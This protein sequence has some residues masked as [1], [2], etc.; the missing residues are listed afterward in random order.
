MKCIHIHIEG[1]VQGVGF[2]PFVYRLA[3]ELG[4]SGWVCNGV[5]GVHVE[6]EGETEQLQKFIQQLKVNHPPIARITQCRIEECSC[7]NFSE[8][9]IAESEFSGKPNLLITPD[10]GLCDDCR[11]EVHN[12]ANHRYQYPFT[13]CTQCGPR[14]SIMRS[15]P[16]DRPATSMDEFAMCPTCLQEYYNP[17]DKRYYSQTNS[18]PDCAIK[19]RL[20]AASGETIASDW[21]S[22]FPIVIQKLHEGSIIAIKGIGGYLLVCDATKPKAIKTLRKRKH[23]PT[24]PFALMY[25][26]IETLQQDACVSDSEAL[27]FLSIQS[28][29]VLVKVKAHPASGICKELIA[30]GLMRM[31]AMQP[32]TAMFDL[33]MAAFGKPLIATSAN[34]S[35]SPII[36][37]DDDALQLL[38][39]I[40]DYFVVHNRD[41]EIAQ[42]D[43]VVQFSSSYNQRIVLRRSRGFAPTVS[44]D[45]FSKETMLAMGAD[46]KSA[47]CLQ[48]NGRI[49][50][51]QYLGDLESYESQESFRKALF[52]LMDLVKAKPKRI[53]IDAHPNY[54]SSQ[55]G[56][57][58]AENWNIP[59]TQVQ[60]HAAHAYAVMA[61]NSLLDTDE[62]IL[63]VIWDGTGYG[64]DGNSWGGE[65]FEYNG[66]SLKRIAQLHYAPV[67][68]GDKMAYDG[69]LAALFIG[70]PSDCIKQFL[71]SKF[72]DVEWPYY[73]RLITSPPRLYTSSAGRLFDAVACLT[74]IN[75]FNSFE[76]ESAMR[77]ETEAMMGVTPIRYVVRWNDNSLD[78]KNLLNQVLK[79]LEEG[80]CPERIAFKF[81]AWLADV[82]HSVV[83]TKQYGKIAFSGGVFQNAL[84]MDLIRERLNGKQ[85]FVHRELSPND[86]TISFGQ[87]ACAVHGVH[88]LAKSMETEYHV[89]PV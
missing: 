2:R 83:E 47:F 54:Y 73:S 17:L 53:I 45:A 50:T 60:H 43:S 57:T 23:R 36:Y 26:D 66:K 87:L 59:V 19:V 25:P 74:G 89:I 62:P 24:K 86:E 15:L 85:L 6:A 72:S 7:Q 79:D 46:M 40:A 51:S 16:Y 31:G 20:L 56:R 55:L 8:F 42:D 13:T 38:S 12:K 30:P 9:R 76:G 21:G 33:M 52:H 63:N 67:W 65:F 29:I 82:I 14:Y 68:Q 80:I 84:L 71:K 75:T 32:Y 34:V 44:M 70:Y 77:L 64:D 88:A 35:G 22:A 69:R 81:H 11:K 3:T 78:T 4:L 49:Y 48:A 10:I 1:Q 39:T 5:D 41:I 58:L 37:K 27:E 18:C 28:P 61:E